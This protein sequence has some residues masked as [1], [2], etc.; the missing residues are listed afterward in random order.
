M[1]EQLQ[2]RTEADLQLLDSR[3]EVAAGL[4]LRVFKIQLYTITLL[5]QMVNFILSATE[6]Y[7]SS[8]V[9]RSTGLN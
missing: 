1:T 7:L 9:S 2:V 5:F 3:L 8:R 4:G 6:A